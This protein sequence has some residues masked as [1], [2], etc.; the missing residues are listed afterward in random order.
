M[1]MNNIYDQFLKLKIPKNEK[2]NYFNTIK[3]K[4][5]NHRIAKNI[6][7]EAVILFD[8]KNQNRGLEAPNTKNLILKFNQHCSIKEG[9]KLENKFLTSHANKEL[10]KNSKR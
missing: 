2:I 4:K 8:V 5:F 6:D 7:N 9:S 3:I 10:Y 1:S